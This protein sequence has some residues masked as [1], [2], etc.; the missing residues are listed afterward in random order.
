MNRI[1]DTISQAITADSINQIFHMDHL[2]LKSGEQQKKSKSA[3]VSKI[4]ISSEIRCRLAQRTSGT[5]F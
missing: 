4:T 2:H 1:I 3:K 5:M